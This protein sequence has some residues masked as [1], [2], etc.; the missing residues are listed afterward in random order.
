MGATALI[1]L[2]LVTLNVSAMITQASVV[3]LPSGKRVILLADQHGNKPTSA[4]QLKNFIDTFTAYNPTN[5]F[6][7][8]CEKVC[9][10]HY[11]SA[12]MRGVLTHLAPTLQQQPI[13]TMSVKIVGAPDE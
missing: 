10:L 2:N 6:L 4:H 5:G 12:K 3:A 11:L 1:I 9:K 8:L 7:T 13:E